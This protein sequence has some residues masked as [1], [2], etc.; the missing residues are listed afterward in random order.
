MYRKSEDLFWL[1]S[2]DPCNLKQISWCPKVFLLDIFSSIYYIISQS[3]REN[4]LKEKSFWTQKTLCIHT[5]NQVRRTYGNILFSGQKRAKRQQKKKQLYYM[6]TMSL[7]SIDNVKWI[8]DIIL[9]LDIMSRFHMINTL[10]TL[11]LTRMGY[12]NIQRFHAIFSIY[13]A[14]TINN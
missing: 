9:Q 6:H 12:E 2:Q 14:K 7:T 13:L 5:T 11:F 3:C 4:S 8:L 1:W 10:F